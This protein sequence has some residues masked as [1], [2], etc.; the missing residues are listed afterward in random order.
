MRTVLHENFVTDQPVFEDAR[1]T[2]PVDAI[3]LVPVAG[4]VGDGQRMAQEDDEIGIG[5]HG[6]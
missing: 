6:L 5:E 3:I 4:G 1:E 2:A